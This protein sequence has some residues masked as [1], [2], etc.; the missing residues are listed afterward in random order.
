[1]KSKVRSIRIIPIVL[2]FIL[3]VLNLYLGFITYPDVGF[4]NY[5]IFSIIYL[6]LGLLLTSNIKFSDLIVFIATL[7]ILFIYPVIIDFKHLHPSSSGI[8]STI[9]AI[10]LIACFILVL[11]KIKD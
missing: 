9:N 5:L 2:L 4:I 10:I 11:L 6:V 3:F 7:A 1:M 8:M